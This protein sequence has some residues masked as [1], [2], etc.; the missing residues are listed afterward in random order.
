VGRSYICSLQNHNLINEIMEGKSHIMEFLL[1]PLAINCDTKKYIFASTV[2]HTERAL[3][4]VEFISGARWPIKTCLC[5]WLGFFVWPL[6]GVFLRE[7]RYAGSRR[8]NKV[9]AELEYYGSASLS[10]ILFAPRI[11]TAVA[12]SERR[13]RAESELAGGGGRV[14]RS[15]RFGRS[16]AVILSLSLLSSRAA[17]ERAEEAA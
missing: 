8:Q 9:W 6:A 17:T 3:S 15:V 10:F 2:T 1:F 13:Q 7:H 12:F 11:I 5:V 14:C 16:S 4:G